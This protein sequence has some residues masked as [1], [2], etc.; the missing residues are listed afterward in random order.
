MCLNFDQPDEDHNYC[1]YSFETVEDDLPDLTIQEQPSY[2]EVTQ[3]SF[4]ITR[5]TESEVEEKLST[6]PL[7]QFQE[8]RKFKTESNHEETTGSTLNQ[9][10]DHSQVQPDKCISNFSEVPDFTNNMS[11]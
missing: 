6:T 8:E 5:V 10:E 3:N 2:L 7:S 1:N 11:Q 9:I 4:A